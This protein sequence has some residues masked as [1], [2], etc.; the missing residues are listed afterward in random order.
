MGIQFLDAFILVPFLLH[1]YFSTNMVAFRTVTA[2]TISTKA[3]DKDSRM[4]TSK[5]HILQACTGPWGGHFLHHSPG[6]SGDGDG[7]GNIGGIGLD[8]LSAAQASPPHPPQNQHLC[9]TTPGADNKKPQLLLEWQQDSRRVHKRNH[10]LCGPLWRSVEAMNEDAVEEEYFEA[11]MLKS[12]ADIR[13]HVNSSK[14]ELP[15][16]LCGLSCMFNNYCRLLEVLF[17]AQLL[18]SGTCVRDT[19]RIR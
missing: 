1:H 16:T 8:P 2:Q 3:G 19:E 9:H 14:V 4:T 10:H 7:G 12:V 6:I 17:W 15:T 5:R 13:K 18:T 11:L